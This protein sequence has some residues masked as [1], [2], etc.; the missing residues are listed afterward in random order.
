MYYDLI[1]V[2]HAEYVKSNINI[3][4]TSKASNQTVW[5]VKEK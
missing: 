5:Q 4:W 3:T 2:K 1:S